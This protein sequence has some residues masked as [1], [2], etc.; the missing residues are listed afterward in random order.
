MILLA[1]LG[2][3][4]LVEKKSLLALPI[5]ALAAQLGWQSFRA[6]FVYSADR[7]NP[8]VYA[9]TVPDIL[10]LF[11]KAEGIATVAPEGFQTIIKVIAKDGDY[12]PL[13]WYLR[14]F[15]KVGWYEKVP[16]DPFA[17]IVIF[18]KSLD[19]RLDER[20]EKKWIMVGYNELR[21]QVFFEMYVELELWKKY[22][23]SLPPVRDEE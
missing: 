13:P 20:S 21:P 22:V 17:P 5:L 16:D 8:Y 11:K 4:A 9:Q 6:S 3:A 10:N 15:E 19:A 14:R 2:A 23:A 12:W 7:R 1:G 18:S